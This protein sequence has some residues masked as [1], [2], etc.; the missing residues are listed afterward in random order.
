MGIEFAADLGTLPTVIESDARGV[1]K[2]INSGKTIFTEISLV[3]SD[4]VSRLSDGSI[5]RVYYVPRRTNIVAH[6]LA[7]LA[8]TVDYDRFWVESFPDCVRHCIHDDL[9]G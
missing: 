1:V 6:S 9:P 2:L 8:I 7:K 5:S 4:T 3:C